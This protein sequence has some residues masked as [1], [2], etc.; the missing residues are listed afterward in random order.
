MRVAVLS[1]AVAWTAS[2]RVAQSQSFDP[3]KIA[4]HRDFERLTLDVAEALALPHAAEPE[5][6][7]RR[8]LG[9]LLLTVRRVDPDSSAWFQAAPNNDPSSYLISP[10]IMATVG[11]P[12]RFDVSL[13]TGLVGRYPSSGFGLKHLLVEGTPRAPGI[14]VGATAAALWG[15]SSYFPAVASI[16]SHFA[17]RTAIG[18][19]ALGARQ[20]LITARGKRGSS[21]GEEVN[22]PLFQLY[23]AY[24]WGMEFGRRSDIGLRAD[25]TLT[26]L[27]LPFSKG[28]TQVGQWTGG[29]YLRR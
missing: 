22:T 21:G 1:L 19:W 13:A 10:R 3:G 14:A 27:P 15:E 26:R 12:Y 5:N 18:H 4:E 8:W 29:V 7:G 23:L 2:A 11:I 25:A 16:Y 17:W 9:E 6:L 20:L 28:P 24:Q